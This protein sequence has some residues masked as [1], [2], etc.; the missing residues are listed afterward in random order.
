MYFLGDRKDVNNRLHTQRGEHLHVLGPTTALLVDLVRR[1]QALFV[2]DAIFPVQHYRRPVN[3]VW[4][5]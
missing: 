2:Y 3:F 1:E 5:F 4:S